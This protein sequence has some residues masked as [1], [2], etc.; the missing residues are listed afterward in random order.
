[1]RLNI[2]PNLTGCISS[3]NY[4]LILFKNFGFGARLYMIIVCNSK[5]F[6]YWKCMSG[7]NCSYGWFLCDNHKYNKCLFLFLQHSLFLLVFL[8]QYIRFKS[9]HALEM[10]NHQCIL[11]SLFFILWIMPIYIAMFF[12]QCVTNHSLGKMSLLMVNEMM[13]M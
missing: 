13:N 11:E 3:C 5:S 9:I 8:L 2:P 12:I 7:N 1:M 10:M 6:H 4:A